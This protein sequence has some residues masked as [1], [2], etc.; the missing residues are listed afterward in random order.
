MIGPLTLSHFLMLGAILFTGLIFQLAAVGM[1]KIFQIR[2][3]ETIGTSAI[4][5]GWRPKRISNCAIW[6]RRPACRWTRPA[7]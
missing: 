4:A 5:A 2:L 7:S 1:P 3:G 6:L